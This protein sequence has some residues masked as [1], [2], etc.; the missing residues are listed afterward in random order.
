M[1]TAL[2]KG[3]KKY[4]EFNQ[5]EKGNMTLTSGKNAK[6]AKLEPGD[7]GSTMLCWIQDF[8][9]RIK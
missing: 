9:L 5:L 2:E 1:C 8:I 4:C 3:K 6:M 7:V